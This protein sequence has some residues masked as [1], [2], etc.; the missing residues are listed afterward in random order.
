MGWTAAAP[1]LG[2]LGVSQRSLS[3]RKAHDPLMRLPPQYACLVAGHHKPKSPLPIFK[4]VFAGADRT[5]ESHS[6]PN[7]GCNDPARDSIPFLPFPTRSRSVEQFLHGRSPPPGRA[8]R[9][10][11]D[12]AANPSA[13]TRVP[14]TPRA[15]PRSAP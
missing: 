15:S 5:G 10:L 14:Q 9:S 7:V 8:K 4:T 1:K 13:R 3:G 6:G 11:G 2:G 12:E